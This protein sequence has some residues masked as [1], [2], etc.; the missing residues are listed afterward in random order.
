MIVLY[1]DNEGWSVLRLLYYKRFLIK[2]KNER[3]IPTM[4]DKYFDSLHV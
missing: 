1:K 4:L 3:L 2:E